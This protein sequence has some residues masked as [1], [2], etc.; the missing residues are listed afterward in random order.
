MSAIT[1]A[2][3]AAASSGAD[4][5]E[6]EEAVRQSARFEVNTPEQLGDTTAAAVAV[7]LATGLDDVRQTLALLQ[8]VGNQSAITDPSKV[9]KNARQALVSGVATVRNQ[10]PEE[11]ARQTG[12]LFAQVTKA[13]ADTQGS[14]SAT[15]TTTVTKE[16]DQF[17][18]S[19]GDELIDARSKVQKLDK[20]IDKGTATEADVRDRNQLKEFVDVGSSVQKDLQGTESFETLFGR[21]ETLQK[22]QPLA[23]QFAGREG[24]GEAR[25]QV[26]L[27]D[28]LDANSEASLGLQE[29]FDKIRADA[30]FFEVEAAFVS[31]GTPELAQA[32]F[33][34]RSASAQAAQLFED[35]DGSALS[36]IREGTANALAETRTPG[37]GGF[38]S[39]Q[40]SESF[41]R[42]GIAKGSTA[43][44][45][46]VDLILKLLQRRL[47]FSN[48]GLTE[49]EAPKVARL[50]AEISSIR[51][52]LRN[53]AGVLAPGSLESASFQA[54]TVAESI[55]AYAPGQEGFF[56]DLAAEFREM[57]ATIERQNAIAQQQLDAA[58]ETATNTKPRMPDP[59]TAQR[60]AAEA[61]R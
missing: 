58:K 25:F 60:A 8:T 39:A 36:A 45:E 5:A 50:D 32:N 51:D 31:S 1:S 12:A 24:F 10:D 16:L 14:S 11:A 43:A 28:I 29:A 15:F 35:K 2:L 9:A 37:I 3:G 22:F 48:D 7:Q 21:I 40:V 47:A 19:F 44:E 57:R 17:F 18:S 34:N 33:R 56:R 42:S 55:N 59:G 54:S 20:K 27:K 30:S 52:L 13:G 26:L 49:E 23:T 38:L 46:S 53:K 41:I 61:S 6:A 4:A